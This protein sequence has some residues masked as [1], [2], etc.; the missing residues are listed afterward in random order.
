MEGGAKCVKYM[1]FIFNF[2]FFLT[3]CGLIGLGVWLNIERDDWEGI[4]DYDY[5]SVANVIIAAGAIIVIVAFLGCCGAITENR[6][7]LLGFFIFLL[8]IFLLEIGAGIAAYVW[9]GEIEDELRIQI[10]K[11][12]PERYYSETGVSKAMNSIQKHFECCGIDKIEDWAPQVGVNSNVGSV[13]GS[14]CKTDA[15]VSGYSSSCGKKLYSIAIAIKE[16]YYSK[17]CY[18]SIR[19]FLEDNLLYVG[20]CGIV[21]SIFQLIGMAFA[22]VLFCSISKSSHVV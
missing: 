17:G 18:A 22:M 14:C 19:D 20:I 10:E 4:S 11:R 8:I 1:V 6:W 12:I 3:G 15:S 16:Q 21:F 2:L 13:D 5:I 9:R 7:M